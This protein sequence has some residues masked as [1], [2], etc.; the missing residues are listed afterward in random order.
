MADFGER[1]SLSIR[2]PQTPLQMSLQDPIFGSPSAHRSPV[3]ALEG[4]GGLT[5]SGLGPR[6]VR[7]RAATFVATALALVIRLPTFMSQQSTEPVLAVLAMVEAKQVNGVAHPSFLLAG[8][9]RGVAGY[10]PC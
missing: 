4:R 8:R 1:H 2:E 6:V 10:N 5:T 7:H 3:S 9:A